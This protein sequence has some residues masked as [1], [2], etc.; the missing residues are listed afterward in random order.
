MRRS[1]LAVVA[2][3]VALVLASSGG[4][5][6]YVPTPM[7]LSQTG[8]SYGVYT[9]HDWKVGDGDVNAKVVA[10]TSP[11]YP[12]ASGPDGRQGLFQVWAPTCEQGAQTIRL[13]RTIE[14]AGPVGSVSASITP[15]TASGFAISSAK[16]FVNGKKVL[17]VGSHGGGFDLK[18]MRLFG[19]GQNVV[20]LEATKAPNPK[21]VASCNSSKQ[22][23]VAIQA[24]VRGEFATDLA[25]VEPKP[26]DQAFDASGATSVAGRI[27][28]SV[29]NKGLGGAPRGLFHLTLAL[30][31]SPV[32][33]ETTFD[34]D[35][36]G[37][38]PF[39][40]CTYVKANV[41][42]YEA[43]CFFSDFRAGTTQLIRVLYHSAGA[44]AA[45]VDVSASVRWNIHFEGE[46][47]NGSNNER[48]VKLWF[49]EFGVAEGR[50]TCKPPP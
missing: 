49:C 48:L 20:E 13:R 6:G 50:T 33:A 29:R 46:D 2:T 9:N 4:A 18:P 27:N 25:L 26:A 30:P 8:Q 15:V 11:V 16:L 7:W 31:T 39:D 5:A 40:K 24:H 22:T 14:L 41:A 32:R 35:P 10:L 45:P 21:G 43:N 23:Q 17:E 38:G 44:K 34:I 1:I 19:F 12:K 47:V 42:T 36:V 28:F 37:N 3:A